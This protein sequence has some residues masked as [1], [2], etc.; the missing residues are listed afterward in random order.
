MNYFLA[1]A[2]VDLHIDAKTRWP[3][4]DNASDGWNGGSATFGS[5]GWP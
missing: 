1:P 2:L 5:R 4:H 3:N